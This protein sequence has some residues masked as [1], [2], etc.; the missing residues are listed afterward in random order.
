MNVKIKRGQHDHGWPLFIFESFKIMK[1]GNGK[2]KFWLMIQNALK[3]LK[4]FHLLINVLN[5]WYCHIFF[6]LQFFL[7]SA[8]QYD[9]LFA[10]GE[11][12]AGCSGCSHPS[13]GKSFDAKN[14]WGTLV[15]ICPANTQNCI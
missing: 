1:M 3:I 6:Q 9:T 7:T 5:A 10:S 14:L 11:S 2:K 4:L 15:F 12:V 8:L 13:V